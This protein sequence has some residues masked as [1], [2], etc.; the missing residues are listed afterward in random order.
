[1]NPANVDAIH[2]FLDAVAACKGEVYLK[3][4]EGDVFNLKSS[5][6]QYI[7]IGKLLEESGNAV[8]ISAE[9]PQEEKQLQALLE[10]LSH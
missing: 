8:F 10:K 4:R 3:S 6:S 7:A 9:D 1:M 5:L 2:A